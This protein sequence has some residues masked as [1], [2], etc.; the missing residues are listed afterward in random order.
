M[1]ATL[2]SVSVAVNVG[3]HSGGLPAIMPSFD[4]RRGSTTNPSSSNVSLISTGPVFASAASGTAW[5]N[6]GNPQNWSGTIDQNNVIDKSQYYYYLVLT[7][8]SGSLAVPGNAY[9]GLSATYG[10]ITSMYFH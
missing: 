6:G 2:T 7:D 8:E 5:H 9:L 10:N 4:I 3:T 1:A